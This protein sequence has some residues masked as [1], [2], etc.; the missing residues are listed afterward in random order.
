MA[1]NTTQKQA[2]RPALKTPEERQAAMRDQLQKAYA[3]VYKALGSDGGGLTRR[4]RN[5]VLSGMS[6]ED[7]QKVSAA[8]SSLLDDWAQA[9]AHAR[10]GPER[11]QLEVPTLFE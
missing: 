6:D 2:G 8:V 9:V 3:K 7:V 4:A 1:K 10:K 5:H 11:V